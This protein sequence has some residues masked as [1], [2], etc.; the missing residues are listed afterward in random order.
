MF[1]FFK[2][3]RMSRQRANKRALNSAALILLFQELYY[4]LEISHFCSS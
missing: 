2:D 3:S 1:I 4:M